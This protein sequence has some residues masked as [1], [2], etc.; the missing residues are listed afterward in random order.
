LVELMVAYWA[1]KWVV[2]LIASRDMRSVG[3]SA[4]R[5]AAGWA[6]T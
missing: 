6:E 2:C 1:G 4:A 3:W 5:T